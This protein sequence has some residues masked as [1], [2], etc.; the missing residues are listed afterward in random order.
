MSLEKRLN[1][2]RLDADAANFHLIVNPPDKNKL[3]VGG[4]LEL[5]EETDPRSL[6]NE[7]QQYRPG[8][9]SWDARNL[10]SSRWTIRVERIDERADTATFLSHTA[11]FA[12]ATHWLRYVSSSRGLASQ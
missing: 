1:F 6:R 9:F 11:P 4:V 8:R 5:N 12:N 10:G 2:T 3:P 7:F